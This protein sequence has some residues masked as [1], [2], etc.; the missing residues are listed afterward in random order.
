MKK[1]L[2]IVFIIFIVGIASY[3]SVN[4]I[5]KKVDDNGNSIANSNN[6]EEDNNLVVVPYV[7]VDESSI[8]I[9]S[10]TNLDILIDISDNNVIANEAEFIIIG[11]IKT[12]DGVINYNP[13]AKCYT[14]NATIGRMQVDKILKGN[15][16]EKEVDFLRGGGMITISEY[17]KSLT[18]EQ[19]EYH[20]IN[21]L[22]QEEKNSKYVSENVAG[23]ISIEK[24]KTYLMYLIY[25][26]DYDR[27]I[28]T[29]F[30]YG[31]REIDKDTLNSDYKYTMVKNN[32]TEEFERLESVLTESVMKNVE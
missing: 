29:F 1:S 16:E 19:V 24:D 31:L 7:D 30:E 6:M 15:I 23:N 9:S 25:S 13:V 12:I 32:K 10:T 28:I 8:F 4:K 26:K 14:M 21:K 22:T 17:E 27:Y 11:T 2:L 5:I 3:V 18:K 20:N